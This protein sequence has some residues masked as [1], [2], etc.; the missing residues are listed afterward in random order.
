MNLI[1][2]RMALCVSLTGLPA[3]VSH[4]Q[5][6]L[7][8]SH[9]ASAEGSASASAGMP[10]PASERVVLKVGNAQVTQEDF[11]SQIGDVEDQKEEGG[12]E[13]DRRKLG[14][15]YASVLMLSQ[16]A[17]AKHLDSTPEVGRQLAVDRIQILS[18]A[19]FASLMSQAQ[20]SVE[21][22]S[23][24]YSAHASD[25]DEVQIRRLFIWKRGEGSKN[26][27]GVSP[28]AARARADAILQASA[29]GRDATKLAG[30]FKDS[31]GGMLDPE[32]LTFP[33]GEL[34]PQIEKAVFAMK[35]GE[36]A[37]VDDTSDAIMLAQM[38]KRDHQHLEQV[39][40]SIQTR[41]Q[42]DKMQALLDEMKKSAGIWMDEKYFGIG[43]PASRARVRDNSPPQLQNSGDTKEE[44]RNDR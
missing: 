36:W 21:E 38:V 42:G 11:E 16:Q 20:P 44:K 3:A 4:A 5:A 2:A 22:V 6:S 31:D 9:A 37:Q 23:Q 17:I 15:D 33:R 26:T 43:A 13:K 8:P 1:R 27:R 32:P 19:E 18:D 34:R 30:E 41:L 10:S 28:Q 25:Y 39:S 7:S 12:S 14:D 35:E 40:S 29:A 24:Y